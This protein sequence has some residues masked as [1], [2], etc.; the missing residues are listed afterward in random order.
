MTKIILTFVVLAAVIG[1]AIQTVRKMTGREV[2]RLTKL[3]GFSIMSAL[4]AVVVM[5]VIVVL[6]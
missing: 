1:L 4:A 3:A 5:A 2:W 6:F